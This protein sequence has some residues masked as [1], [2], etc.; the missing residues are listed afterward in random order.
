[1][2]YTLIWLIIICSGNQY[3][4]SQELAQATNHQHEEEYENIHSTFFDSEEVV[5]FTLLAN[6]KSILK[7]RGEEPEEHP[8][9]LLM[10]DSN[11][12]V[13]SIDLKLEVRGNFR[14]KNCSFPP[15]RFDFPKKDILSTMFAGENKLKLVTHCR[16]NNDAFEQ[17]VLKEYLTYKIYNY[18]TDYSFK[19]R[20]VNVT[21]KD[22]AGKYDDETRYGFL[23]EDDDE[24]AERHGMKILKAQNVHPDA[25][26]RDVA[27]VMAIYEYMIGN[28]DWSIPNLHNVKLLRDT[29]PGKLPIPVPYDF[30]WC[31]VVN[32]PYAKPNPMFKTSS[33]RQRV[34]RGFC[35]SEEEFQQAFAVFNREKER[36][37]QLIDSFTQLTDK[38]KEKC[39]SYLDDF[40]ETINSESLTKREILA[41]CR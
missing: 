2:R 23:I 34:F 1:M 39:V 24:L 8:A 17:N 38:E 33:V 29:V 16:S 27:N 12:I 31:G 22:S 18:L 19:V 36:I 9:K 28:T 14:K 11:S 30:D 25:T 40:Y 5:S 13:D 26:Q 35:R 41:N 4:F 32:A 15:L 10:T 37:Y 20:L 3:V 21:Y 6:F 7:D